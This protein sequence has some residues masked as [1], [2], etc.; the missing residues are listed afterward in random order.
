MNTTAPHTGARRGSV[1]HL[2]TPEDKSFWEREGEAVAKINHGFTGLLRKL[3]I[4]VIVAADVIRV[5]QA[6]QLVHFQIVKWVRFL[7]LVPLVVVAT[8][9]TG[10]CSGRPTGAR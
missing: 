4:G 9:L 5:Q 8:G 10:R 1:L 3:K 2:W 7:H 6:Q